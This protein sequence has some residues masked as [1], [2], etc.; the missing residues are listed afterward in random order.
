MSVQNVD[1]HE[2]DSLITELA[3]AP[4]T[5]ISIERRIELCRECIAGVFAERHEWAL[6]AVRVCHV[7][8]SLDD[9]DRAW[10]EVNCAHC[11]S[12]HGSARTTGLDLRMMQTD[13]GKYGVFK[14]PVAAGKG[15]GGRRYDIVPGKPDESI[16][17]FRLETEEPGARM[18]NIARNLAHHES[19]DLIRSWIESMPVQEKQK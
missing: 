9:C 10:L 18:P 13:P 7:Q 17:M 16:L 12:P 5:A 4:Q 14:S 6:Q 11:H 8:S 15:T 19:N 2:I 3:S 1:R